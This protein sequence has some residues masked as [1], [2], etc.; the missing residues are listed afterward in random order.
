MLNIP[1]CLSLSR[2]VLVPVFCMLYLNARR[3]SDFLWAGGVLLLSGLTDLLDGQIARR[4]H[5]VTQLGKLLD[6]LA[7]KLTQIAVCICIAIRQPVFLLLLC[8]FIVKE[9][10]MLAGGVRLLKLGKQVEGA[11]WFGKL[12]TCVFYGVMLAII[13]LP[14]L[15]TPVVFALMALSCGMMLLAFFLYLPV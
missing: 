11:K 9:L 4:R 6:P 3:P 12:S 7:D 13:S 2:I 1:N 14:Q 10:L 8:V 5:Q 15:P